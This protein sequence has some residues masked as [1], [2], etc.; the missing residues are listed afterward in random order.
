METKLMSGN[1]AVARGA[2]ESGVGLAAAYPG[3]PSTEIVENIARFQEMEALWSNNE[4]IA[5]ETA[6]GASM[7]GHRVVAAMKHVG[8]NVAMDALMNIAYSGVNGGYVVVSA[9]DPGQHS[10][11]NEQD[12][13]ILARF[14][15]IPLIEPS[16]SQEAKDAVGLALEMSEQFDTPVM[17]RL[18]T[19]I[20]HSESPVTL[21]ERREVSPKPYKKDV[22][23]YVLL[24][25]FSRDRRRKMLERMPTL[26]AFSENHPS[27]SIE[28]GEGR[29]EIGIVTSSVGYNY[30]KDVLPEAAVMKILITNPLPADRIREF[31]GSVERL[32]VVEELEPYLEEQISALGIRVE[33][34]RFFPRIGELSPPVVRRG[35]VEAGILPSGKKEPYPPV[36]VTPRPPVMCSGC[37]HRGMMAAIRKLRKVMTT[38]DIGCYNLGAMP[39]FSVYDSTICMGAS[40]GTAIGFERVSKDKKVV[41]VIGDSTFLHTGLSALADAVYQKSGI[42]L[43]LLNNRVTAMTGGQPNPASGRDAKGETAPLVDFEAI[44][45]ALGV[46]QVET[47]DAYDYHACRRALKRATSSGELSV[48]LT[49]RPCVMYPKKIKDDPLVVDLEACDA[50]GLCYQLGCPAITGSEIIGKKFPKAEIDPDSCTGCGVCSQICKVEAINTPN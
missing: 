36:Q 21:G 33:G 1:E 31:A 6:F 48:I 37:P 19:R 4:K 32:L 3:T 18:T 17:V 23:K 50:C 35:F 7:A 34:K 39:P 47:V 45:R 5:M 12:N 16:D 38:G 40:L 29:S 28:N 49:E 14:A 20:S 24:P 26:Q 41:A 27:L 44:C 13:R 11:Q 25:G 9:D 15:G 46:R 2:F 10:S 22:R 43:V 30:V 8:V 42:T